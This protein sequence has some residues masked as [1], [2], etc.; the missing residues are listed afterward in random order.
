MA[1][2]KQLDVVLLDIN[3][4]GM[5][6]IATAEQLALRAPSASIIMMSVQ[7]EPDYLDSVTDEAA[8]DGGVIET[9]SGTPL[10]RRLAAIH[11]RVCDLISEHRPQAL[12][13]EELYF[14]KNV[15]TA[16]AVG[17]ARGEARGP[18]VVREV[19]V[20]RPLQR[21]YRQHRRV[22][23]HDRDDVGKVMVELGGRRPP[24]DGQLHDHRAGQQHHEVAAGQGA[25]T[26]TLTIRYRRPTPLQAEVQVEGR[27]VNVEGRKVFATG[28]IRHAGEVTA[29]AEGIFIDVPAAKFVA[30]G[31]QH[32]GIV[33]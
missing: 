27:T 28:E 24:P 29:E 23:D 15:R 10:E 17:Q 20:H 33:A 1:N 6:G 7:G 25:M 4:P 18:E 31:D 8:L 19:P 22:A 12:A 32:P 3:M 9:R 2:E 13:V 26:G 21:R 5:D 16:L 14:G 11:A 30:L